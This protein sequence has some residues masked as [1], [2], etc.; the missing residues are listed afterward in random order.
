M[1][2]RILPGARWLPL[3]FVVTGALAL[4]GTTLVAI[5][6]MLTPETGPWR[7]IYLFGILFILKFPFIILVCWSINRTRERPD[8]PGVWDREEQQR[9]IHRI[10]AEAERIMASDDDRAAMLL[11]HLAGEAWLVADRVD[12]ALTPEAVALAVALEARAR[13]AVARR[14]IIDHGGAMSGR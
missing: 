10:R 11:R 3:A 1:T 14:G 7:G 13:E 5:A 2:G 12:D 4:F 9:I 8:R 6:P